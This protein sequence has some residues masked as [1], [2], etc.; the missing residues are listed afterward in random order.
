MH[1]AC[2]HACAL[3]SAMLSH[4]AIHRAVGG[5]Y[6]TLTPTPENVL[7]HTVGQ[8]SELQDHAQTVGAP[9]EKQKGSPSVLGPLPSA[10]A[11]TSEAP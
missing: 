9:Q 5:Q 8:P 10:S 7:L 6:M 4:S 3:Q 2:N 11:H 1:L